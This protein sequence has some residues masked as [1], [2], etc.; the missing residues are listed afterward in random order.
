MILTS[1]R[2]WRGGWQAARLSSRRGG[3]QRGLPRKEDVIWGLRSEVEGRETERPGLFT[4]AKKGSERAS[5]ASQC[6]WLSRP[7]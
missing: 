7:A 3:E 2:V 1:C 6:Q 5:G 4:R